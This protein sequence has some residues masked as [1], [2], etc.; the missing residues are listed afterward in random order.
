MSML[1]PY[2]VERVTILAANNKTL[3]LRPF[4]LLTQAGEISRYRAR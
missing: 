3:P 4:A 1:A 2:C